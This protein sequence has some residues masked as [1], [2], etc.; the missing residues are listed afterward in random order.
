MP[1]HLAADEHH[2]VQGGEKTYVALT[3]GAECVLGL[4]LSPTADDAGLAKAYGVFHDEAQEL[5]PNYGPETVSIDGWKATQNAWRTWFPLVAVI[6]CFLHGFLK[7]RDRCRKQ[8]DLHSRVWE[9]YRAATAAEFNCR[10]AAFRAWCQEQTW[11]TPVR[12]ALEKLWRHAGEY[13]VSYAHPGCHRTSNLIDRLTN[14]LYRVLYAGRHLHGHLT[15]AERRLRGWAL[16]FN[17]RPYA[18]R[19]GQPRT[20]DSRAH[21]LNNKRYHSHW[22][23]NLQIS[24]SLGGFRSCT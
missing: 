4:A 21:R 3:A 8:V 18:P 2:T 9:V 24:A 10:I 19:A 13:V 22:L 1:A 11:T 14:P 6:L 23:H 16:L 20:H 7:I 5:D 12:E 15:T 17:F